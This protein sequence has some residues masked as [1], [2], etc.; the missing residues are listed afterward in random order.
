MPPQRIVDTRSGLGGSARLGAGRLVAVTVAGRAGIPPT[1]TAAVINVTAVA[2]A[3]GG[4]LSVFPCDGGSADTSVLNYAAGEV[5]AN[6]TIATLDGSGRFCVWTLAP[7]DVL[8]D[9]TG[10]LASGSGSRLTAIDPVRVADTRSGL[11]GSTRLAPGGVLELDLSA[12]VAPTATA[13]ALNVTAVGA[14]S[15]GFLAAYP[16]GGDLPATSTVNHGPGEVRPNNAVVGLGDGRV[17]VFSLAETDVLVD[18][19]GYFGPTGLGYVPATPQRLIDTRDAVLPLPRG[20]VVQYS[21]GVSPYG[22]PSAASV[23]ITAVDHALPGFASTYA[24]G[25]L[26]DTST[27]NVEVGRIAANGAIVPATGSATSCA[28]TLNGGHLLVDLAGWW[29]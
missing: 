7:S 27:L 19:A 28:F 15:G 17:C 12:R 13:V 11:G 23:N 3:G 21:L 8:V 2:P 29:V 24:C 22:V 26:P 14:S 10:W 18:L 6:A 1:A 25:A 20:G 16:C 9:I 4:Y 5:V